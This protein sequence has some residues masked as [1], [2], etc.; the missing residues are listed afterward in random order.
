MKKTFFGIASFSLVLIIGGGLFLFNAKPTYSDSSNLPL[1]VGGFY[2]FSANG[3]V[4]VF[5][6]MTLP[7]SSGWMKVY[8]LV[9]Q[10]EP[11]FFT[12]YYKATQNVSC[13]NINMSCLVRELDK[14]EYRE[15]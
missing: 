7:E 13:L 2:E 9:E 10:T 5:K 3:G 6:I 11:D 14:K 1:K 8:S 15:K 12:H 4:Y